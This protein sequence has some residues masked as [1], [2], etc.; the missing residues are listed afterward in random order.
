MENAPLA[1][2]QPANPLAWLCDYHCR[3]FHIRENTLLHR[4]RHLLNESPC[5]VIECAPTVSVRDV[6][7][8]RLR[9]GYDRHI[10]TGLASVLRFVAATNRREGIRLDRSLLDRAVERWFDR[11]RT[12]ALGIGIDCR[13]HPEISKIKCYFRLI[14]APDAVGEVLAL[15]RPAIHPADYRIHDR[16]IF[17]IE[18]YFDGKTAIEIYPLL[19]Y[20]DLQNGAWMNRLGFSPEAARWIA[21]STSLIVSFAPDGKRILHFYPRHPTRFVRMTRLRH[22]ANAYS[23]VQI[24]EHLTAGWEVPHRFNTI[25][26][27]AE[28][29][30]GAKGISPVTLQYSLTLLEAIGPASE[31]PRTTD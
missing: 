22:L 31:R 13:Q 6:H 5:T 24:A 18:M 9:A 26:T 20:G 15:H 11:S 12:T 4:F 21:A 28:D 3:A 27:M 30:I 17:G 25:F 1:A 2:S 29:D 10:E 8:G 23:H 19:D 16:L 14:D 7:A